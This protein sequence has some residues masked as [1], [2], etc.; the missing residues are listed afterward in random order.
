MSQQ[1]SENLVT[2]V[3]AAQELGVS[4]RTFARY[5]QR[6]IVAVVREGRRGRGGEALFSR[7]ALEGVRLPRAGRPSGESA[8]EPLGPDGAIPALS[9]ADEAKI[10]AALQS[11]RPS[12]LLENLADQWLA[13]AEKFAPNRVR[14]TK[15]MHPTKTEGELRGI[16]LGEVE[17][18]EDGEIDADGTFRPSTVDP[19]DSGGE[20][21]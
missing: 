12:K 19:L 20:M 6:G 16:A 10:S 2:A 8:P 9:P 21:P 1:T 4:G 13:S 5:V 11:G 14:R 18:I 3:E 15:A 7:R 17:Y